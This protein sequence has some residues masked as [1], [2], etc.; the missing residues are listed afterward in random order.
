MN[1]K[2]NF[3]THIKGRQKRQPFICARHG[4]LLVGERPLGAVGIYKCA[5]V[6]IV[7]CSYRLSDAFLFEIQIKF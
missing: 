2:W 4:R 5:A 1:D 6:S 7:D 3:L